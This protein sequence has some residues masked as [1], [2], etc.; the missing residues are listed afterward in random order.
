MKRAN[1]IIIQILVSAVSII[2]I[3]ILSSDMNNADRPS[4]AVLVG[5]DFCYGMEEI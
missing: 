2:C 4:N 1:L 5:F 3:N